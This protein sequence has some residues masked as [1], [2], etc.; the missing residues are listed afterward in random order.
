M[1]PLRRYL[2]NSTLD[3]SFGGQSLVLF[4]NSGLPSEFEG[5]Y[6]Q[7]RLKCPAGAAEFISDADNSPSGPW[8]SAATPVTGCAA[9]STLGAEQLSW[10]LNDLA[11]VNR[12]VTPWVIVA[13]HAP[14]VR[15]LPFPSL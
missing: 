12:A 10:F 6:P 2:P 3:V 7:V 5:N 1:A 14:P 4:G 8:P 13:W 15:A 11:R 9:Q